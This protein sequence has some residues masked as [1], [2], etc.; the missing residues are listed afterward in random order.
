[1]NTPQHDVEQK[2]SGFKDLELEIHYVAGIS[3]DTEILSSANENFDPDWITSDRVREIYQLIIDYYLKENIVL[4]YVAYAK[5]RD[6]E[7]T[8]RILT[9]NAWKKIEFEKRGAN[10]ASTVAARETLQNLY[11]LRCCQSLTKFM[12]KKL[13]GAQESKQYKTDD[14]VE[15]L[16]E[17]NIQTSK[18]LAATTSELES[19]YYEFKKRH[20]IAA[21]DP[22]LNSGVLTGV[23]EIDDPMMGLRDGEFGIVLGN[24]GSG[25]SIM[26]MNFAINCWMN[27]GDAIIVTIEMSKDD[28]LDRIFSY[29]SHI[30][31][32]RFRREQL[33]EQ[34]WK[35]LD[36]IHRKM[37]AYVNKLHI[38][39]IAKGC[40]M[41]TLKGHADKIIKKNNVRGIFID[42]LNIMS[43]QNGEVSLEWQAQVALAIQMKLQIAR[44]LH[45]PTWT[46]G[47][48][49]N[50]NNGAAF[51]SHIQDQVD[52]GL[53]LKPNDETKQTGYLP[54]Q[55]I[56]TRNFRAAR[57]VLDTHY[58]IMSCKQPN[59]KRLRRAE[60]LEEHDA[61]IDV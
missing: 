7:D 40:N 21:A 3:K 53:Q 9:L 45:K 18:T 33:N 41:L 58:Q 43:Q 20:Q 26:L 25:K 22:T 23:K 27:Y 8:D 14:V 36:F 42:Y 56:K 37:K 46:L 60:K 29:L 49:T 30:Q 52:V 61:S 6:K 31:F 35:Y 12:I 16:D 32:S 57:I 19:S 24:T 59:L 50:D 13:R 5:M 48:T 44:E 51:S 4:D 54:A 34:E 2:G 11:N 47:Q 1:M 55:F 10:K 17:F 38:I 28:Y 15:K 39:D